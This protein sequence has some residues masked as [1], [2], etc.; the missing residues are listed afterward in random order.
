MDIDAQPTWRRWLFL[1]IGWLAV[2]LGLIGAVLPVMPTTPFL[3]VALWAFA[4]SSQRFHD[5]LYYHPLFGA[6]LQQWVEHR[7]ISRLGKLLA[8]GAISVGY[9]GL[10]L[11]VKAPLSVTAPV[12][13]T[14]AIL[15]GYLLTRPSYPPPHWEAAAAPDASSSQ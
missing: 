8:V 3:L 9:I 13:I 12:G 6:P 5:W 7:V 10:V 15:I 14:L 2:V 11:L 1:S 4:R